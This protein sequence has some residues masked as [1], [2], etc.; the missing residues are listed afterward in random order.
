MGM[1]SKKTSTNKDQ[2]ND[3]RLMSKNVTVLTHK[4]LGFILI[5]T[6]WHSDGILERIFRESWT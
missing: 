3:Y 4:T 5:Q 6:V 2:T 1:I